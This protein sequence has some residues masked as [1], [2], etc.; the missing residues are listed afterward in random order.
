MDSPKGLSHVWDW[1]NTAV[2][3]FLMTEVVPM[4]VSHLHSF[5]NVTWDLFSIAQLQRILHLLI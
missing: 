3:R 2:S 4:S 1:G 5:E